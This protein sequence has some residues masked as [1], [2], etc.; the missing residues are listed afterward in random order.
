MVFS[1]MFWPPKEKIRVLFL[2][3]TKYLPSFATTC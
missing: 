1:F 3:T 2:F